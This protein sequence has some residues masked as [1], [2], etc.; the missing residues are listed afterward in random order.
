MVPMEAIPTYRV[1]LD[2]S[3]ITAAPAPDVIPEHVR[4][5]LVAAYRPDWPPGSQPTRV[6]DSPDRQRS[7]LPLEQPVRAGS[8]SLSGGVRRSPT[9]TARPAT[10]TPSPAV[11]LTSDVK[12]LA[13][14]VP[15]SC[16]S[17]TATCCT[18]TRPSVTALRNGALQLRDDRALGEIDHLR[19]IRAIHRAPD[20]GDQAV[21]D[22]DL[23]P[24]PRS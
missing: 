11:K 2:A 7:L 3:G 19:T 10:A 5:S 14:T 16:R 4:H 6:P 23:R 1:N 13:P 9:S 18:P 17:T 15:W 20:F 8:A 12:V 21:A 24:S 22:E